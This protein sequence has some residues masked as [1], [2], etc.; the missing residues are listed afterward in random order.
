[1]DWEIIRTSSRT[2]SSSQFCMEKSVLCRFSAYTL[3]QKLYGSNQFNLM[4]DKILLAIPFGKIL[5]FRYNFEK[6]G[7]LSQKIT[8]ELEETGIHPL[9]KLS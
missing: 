2:I 8:H 9:T 5:E 1:M 3:H 6:N 7:I 4:K